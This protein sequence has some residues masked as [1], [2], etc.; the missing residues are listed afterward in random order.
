MNLLLSYNIFYCKTYSFDSFFTPVESNKKEEYIYIIGTPF[1]LFVYSPYAVSHIHVY[2]RYTMHM[3]EYYN[4]VRKLTRPHTPMLPQRMGWNENEPL[5]LHT[6]TDTIVFLLIAHAY[7]RTNFPPIHGCYSVAVRFMR[8][9]WPV[10]VLLFFLY[11]F[12]SFVC[13][14]Q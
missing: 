11:I 3:P 9:L 2:L 13:Q 8:F 5:S 1:P 4:I 7:I 14:Q 12:F 10:V 6:Y